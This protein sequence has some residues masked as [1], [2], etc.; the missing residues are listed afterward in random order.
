[1]QSPLCDLPITV[2]FIVIANSCI[3]NGTLDKDAW[4][5]MGLLFYY[6][7][8]VMCWFF[9]QPD[10]GS[11][12]M[13]SYGVQQ[14]QEGYQ[15]LWSHGAPTPPPNM[16]LQQPQLQLHNTLQ[17][18]YLIVAAGVSVSWAKFSTLEVR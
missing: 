17:W 11:F 9:G 7:L 1:M 6:G 14:I 18:Y 5:R 8:C 15:E 13:M 10:L 16:E 2:T 4:L 12:Y 3:G